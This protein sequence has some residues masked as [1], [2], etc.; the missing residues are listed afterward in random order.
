M[1]MDEYHSL[2]P[3]KTVT[4]EETYRLSDP[5]LFESI[6]SMSEHDSMHQTQK[7]IR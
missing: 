3:A 5:S 7:A 1:T 6:L 2:I 4:A